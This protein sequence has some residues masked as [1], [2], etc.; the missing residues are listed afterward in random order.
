MEHLSA[1]AHDIRRFLSTDGVK[2]STGHAQQLLA[3]AFGHN[4][5]ASYQAS[6]EDGRLR[7]AIDIVVDEAKLQE[8][9]GELACPAGSRV[10]S[11]VQTALASRYS[12]ATLHASLDDFLGQL[13]EYVDDRFTADARAQADS[14]RLPWAETPLPWK[15][16]DPVGTSDLRGELEGWR[17]SG[18]DE[19]RRS[20]DQEVKLSGSIVVRRLG[21]RLF[22]ARSVKAMHAQLRREGVGP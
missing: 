19:D 6:G 14:A 3:A 18:D 22:G 4:N 12:L 16:I 5:L 17:V 21:R 2:L 15:S 9:A 1:L 8:R 10:V 11:A 13:Q 7:F 20:S